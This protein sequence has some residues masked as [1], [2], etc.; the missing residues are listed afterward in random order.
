MYT[1]PYSMHHAVYLLLVHYTP[2]PCP[3]HYRFITL[4]TLHSRSNAREPFSASME[5]IRHENPFCKHYTAEPN[6]SSWW[7]HAQCAEI[8]STKDDYSTFIKFYL[9][10]N[11][12][13]IDQRPYQIKRRARPCEKSAFLWPT[14]KMIR[15][16]SR[17]KSIRVPNDRLSH[18]PAARMTKKTTTATGFSIRNKNSSV[19]VSRHSEKKDR[20]QYTRSWS[21]VSQPRVLWYVSVCMCGRI[22][23]WQWTSWRYLSD[24]FKRDGKNATDHVE[25]HI[26][27]ASACNVYSWK[28][29]NNGISDIIQ[30]VT[31]VHT[32][33]AGSWTMNTICATYDVAIRM[34]I[35]WLSWKQY[36]HL[37]A[38]I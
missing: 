24:S 11:V 5:N 16:R 29:K 37:S 38:S 15:L 34:R 27:F 2:C 1:V 21:I 33:T 30:L 6:R 12:W 13:L 7:V 35:E 28:E 9:H 22:S 8:Q 36:Q 14:K 19:F 3:L 25:A 20:M 31:S 23:L 32:T 10:K 17:V 26:F 4:L 18:R